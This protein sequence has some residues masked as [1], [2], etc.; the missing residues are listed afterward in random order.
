MKTIS[1]FIV[2]CIMVII[3][4][5]GFYQFYFWCQRNHKSK[6]KIIH[7]K[8]DSLIPF[9]PGWVW[10]Y[11]GLYYPVIIFMIFAFKDFRH[12][13]YV[14]VDFAILMAFQMYFFVYHPV[15]TPASWREFTE[16]KQTLSVRFLKYVQGIDQASNCFPSMHVSVATL[17]SCHLLQNMP[18][19][20]LWVWSF[21]ILIAISAVF[22]KQHYFKD[23]IPGAILGFAAYGIFYSFY[24]F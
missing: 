19:L 20:G 11:S 4:I 8:I 12:F 5:I 10:I 9:K 18:F 6:P 24:T 16:H 17:T 23:L 22:T 21:P 15:T 7:S 1:D 2:M 13:G 3:L 14:V